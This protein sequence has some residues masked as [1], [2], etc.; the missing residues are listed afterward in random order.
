MCPVSHVRCRMSLV[1]CHMWCV[2]C[3]VSRVRVLCL[4][5]FFCHKVLELAGGG[6][7]I[8]R[9]YFFLFLFFRQSAPGAYF[10]K[11]DFVISIFFS[12]NLDLGTFSLFGSVLFQS[13]I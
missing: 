7:L 8:N 5:I 1:M 6:S 10:Q 11:L 3:P 4:N 12:S 2:M 9:A 13:Q